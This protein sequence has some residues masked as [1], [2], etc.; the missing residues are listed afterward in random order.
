MRNHSEVH[1]HVCPDPAAGTGTLDPGV[2]DD[3]VHTGDGIL[4]LADLYAMGLASQTLPT[5]STRH[6]GTSGTASGSMSG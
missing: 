4:V 1:G 2:F 6:G 3:M 5:I